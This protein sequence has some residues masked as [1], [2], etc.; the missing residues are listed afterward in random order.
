MAYDVFKIMV[1]DPTQRSINAGQISRD[2][3]KVTNISS[4]I[5]LPSPAKVF[6]NYTMVWGKRISP[7]SPNKVILDASDPNY[8]GELQFLE[9]GKEGGQLIPIRYIKG[10]NSLDADYQNNRIRVSQES[11]K[12]SSMIVLESGVQE[13]NPKTDGMFITFL[14]VHSQCEQ[15]VSKDKSR[16]TKFSYSIIN[17][18]TEKPKQIRQQEKMFDAGAIVRSLDNDPKSMISLHSILGGESVVGVRVEKGKD[19][20][21]YLGLLQ[22]ASDYGD[23]FIAK[24]EDF[25]KEASDLFLKAETMGILDLT[26]KGEIAYIDKQQKRNIL[27]SDLEGKDKA[28]VNWVVSN[29]Y[30]VNAYEAIQTLKNRIK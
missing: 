11:I 21:L 5:V 22:Y 26:K 7:E 9:Y 28:M 18:D 6:G 10:C 30:R 19:Y 16:Y 20:N 8:H 17:E 1:G 15:S 4:S 29:C 27:I 3:S 24:V 23:I 12:E 2:R 13:F 25:K 14:K